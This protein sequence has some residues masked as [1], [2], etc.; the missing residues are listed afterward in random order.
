MCEE[1]YQFWVLVNHSVLYVQVGSLGRNKERLLLSGMDTD[2]PR[3]IEYQRGDQDVS[4][5]KAH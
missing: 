1:T 2:L 4:K 3:S 5:A